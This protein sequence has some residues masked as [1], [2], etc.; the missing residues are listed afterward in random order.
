[1]IDAEL[2][3]LDRQILDRDGHP[4]LAV[5]DLVL[6][7]DDDGRWTIDRVIL[8]SGLTTRF[9]GAHRPLATRDT[10][11]WH[12]VTD[13]GYVLN[14]DAERD[15]V[16]ALWRERWWRDQVISKIPGGNHDPG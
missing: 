8:G 15:E 16:A 2:N 11:D 14:T 10:L 4:M 13:V 9:F 12:V 3:L 1:L 5:G 6:E 7:R